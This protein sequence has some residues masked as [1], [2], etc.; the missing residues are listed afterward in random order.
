MTLLKKVNDNYEY[1]I[2]TENKYIIKYNK[3]NTY[4][5]GVSFNPINGN[6]ITSINDE[7]IYSIIDITLDG[8]RVG[9]ISHGKKTIFKQI[10]S[11]EF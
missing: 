10:L 4:K 7:L 8:N 9:F 11:E 3:N 1:L 2:V 5:M 6:I